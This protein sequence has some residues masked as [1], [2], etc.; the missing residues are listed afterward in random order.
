MKREM[1]SSFLKIIILCITILF[2]TNCTFF[3]KKEIRKATPEEIYTTIILDDSYTLNKYLSEGFPI[4]FRDSSDETLLMKALKNNSLKS[5]ETLLSRGIDLEQQDSYGKTAIFYV[6]SIEALEKMI[7]NGANINF[8]IPSKQLS[9]LTYFI[10]FKPIDYSLLLVD[11]GVNPYLKDES[12]W[13]STF[14]A[15]VDGNGE[16]IKRMNE[17]GIDF[18]QVD[19]KGNYPIYYAFNEDIILELLNVK[20]YNLKKINSQKENVLGE[21]YL[22]AVA[23]GYPTVVEKILKLGVNPNYTSYGDSAISILE[24]TKNPDIIKFFNDNNIK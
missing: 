13:D 3:Q 24:K 19:E 11:N 21:I 10:K 6:R 18:L 16:L 9:L 17:K 7:K 4:D 1:K 8:V 2:F 23:N 12:G 5:L 15:A 14:W 22:R 20:N